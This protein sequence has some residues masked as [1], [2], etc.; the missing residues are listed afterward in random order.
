MRGASCPKL[1]PSNPVRKVNLPADDV[2][3]EA[4]CYYVASK[5]L[6]STIQELVHT[7]ICTVTR[8]S[9][10]ILHAAKVVRGEP[11]GTN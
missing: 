11:K 1:A 3:L 7:Q 4:I 10:E 8:T 9:S 2:M 6:H 5:Y